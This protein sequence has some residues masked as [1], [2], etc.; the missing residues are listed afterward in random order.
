LITVH[1]SIE[2]AVNLFKIVEEA[3]QNQL[4]ALSAAA[5]LGTKPIPVRESSFRA[6]VTRQLE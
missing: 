5:G 3:C 4:L 1:E 6:D 2:A